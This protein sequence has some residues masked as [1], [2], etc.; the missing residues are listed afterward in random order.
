[1]HR[2]KDSHLSLLNYSLETTQKMISFRPS[3]QLPWI[4]GAF[5]WMSGGVEARVSPSWSHLKDGYSFDRFVED[6]RRTYSS[7]EEYAQRKTAFESNFESIMDHNHQS[8]AETGGHMLGVNEFADRFANELFFG[9]DKAPARML[10][11]DQ[12]ITSTTSRSLSSLP[13]TID[14]IGKLPKQVD[15]R[16]RGVVTPV[17]SQGMCG[18]CWAFA[19][20]AVLESH[21]AMQTNILMELSEQQLVSCA[22]NHLHC[23]GDGG[24]SGATAE[25]AFQHVQEL[26][27]VSEWSFGYQSGS[28]GSNVTCAL[29]V[30]EYTSRIMRNKTMYK[31][32][33]ATISGYVSLA[34]NDYQ[35]LMNA[36]AKL[37]PV[38]VSVAASPWKFYQGGVFDVPWNSSGASDINHLVVLDGYGTDRNTGEDFWLVR[39]SW[40]PL[41]GERV[42]I[43]VKRVD[44]HTLA[45]PSTACGVDT[46]PSDG[47]ACSK[48]DSGND[49]TPP[50]TKVCGTS[51]ILYHATV[52]IG[53]HL[54]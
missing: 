39:N 24:C 9:Y 44:P 42:Y 10:T 26:G 13:I 27:I 29:P 21:I 30:H 20:A 41:W 46:T 54:L 4:A 47:D 40:G 50:A 1:M 17:K 2:R 22:P 31:D 28:N 19:S 51:G 14:T 38:A 45:D 3:S 15:W 12:N 23:G 36:V 11:S 33:V 52:P 43:R 16:K 53:G 6:F 7:P 35:V 37:G 8:E 49:V 5:F 18:S 34:T 32:S 25:I 48:D